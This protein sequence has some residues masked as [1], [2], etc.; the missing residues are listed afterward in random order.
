MGIRISRGRSPAPAPYE[1]YR[2]PAVEHERV[3]PHPPV[4]YRH[5]QSSYL[6]PE[7]GIHRSRSQGRRS[8]AP[9]PPPPPQPVVITNNYYGS[10]SEEEF[11][12]ERRVVRPH[13]SHSRHHS[14]GDSHSRRA[15]PDNW[16]LERTRLE[17]ERVK[18]EAKTEREKLIREKE[19]DHMKK[20]M[21]WKMLRNEQKAKEEEERR[22][23][24]AKEAVEHFRLKKEE[25]EKRRQ[26]EIDRYKAEEAERAKKR[27]DELERYRAEEAEKAAKKK[28]EEMEV[29]Q[30]YKRME[31]DRLAREKKEKDEREAEYQRRLEEDLR[32]S[33]LDERQ[34]AVVTK[35]PLPPAAAPAAEAARPTY[36]RMS[37]RHLSVETLKEFRIDFEY[38]KMVRIPFPSPSLPFSQT[39]TNTSQDPDYVLIKRWV[40]EYEQDFLWEQTKRLREGRAREDRR[41]VI[42][43][44]APSQPLIEFVT[45]EDNKKK[46]HHKEPKM[47]LVIEKKRERSRSPAPAFVR[48]AAGGR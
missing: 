34:I 18:L 21:E 30:N 45:I 9:P 3:I 20:E 10:D 33:G 28:K 4:Y 12:E 42:E 1:T 37:R 17:M 46:H 32:K 24:E 41:L 11:I 48:W 44:P 13:R 22:E 29:I 8:P 15:S 40:P 35:K 2:R 43:R 47:Q 19:K 36:T 27:Q 23:K 16:E 31:A 25:E 5:G 26:L 14:H 6:E 7:I 39:H 38:D